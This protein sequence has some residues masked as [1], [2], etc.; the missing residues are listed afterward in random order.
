VAVKE[1]IRKECQDEIKDTLYKWSI[2]AIMR[3]CCGGLPEWY[4]KRLLGS[5]FEESASCAQDSAPENAAEAR[6]TDSQH[7]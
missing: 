2:D 1:D 5:Q 7:G 3:G 6:F 4:K